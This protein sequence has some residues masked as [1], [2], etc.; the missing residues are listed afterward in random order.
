MAQRALPPGAVRR[1]TAFGLFDADGW[2]W[3]TIKATFW[4]LLILFLLGYVPDRFYYFTVSP[5]IDVG[6]NVIS[7]INLCPGENRLSPCPAPAGAVVP[8]EASP[9]QLALPQPRVGAGTVSSGENVYV[10]GGNTGSGATDS[11]L[12]SLLFEGNLTEWQEAT[13]LPDARSDAAV[14]SL[15]GTP[16]VIGGNDGAGNP[17][18][19]VFRGVIEEGR[20]TGWEEVE[21]NPLPEPLADLAAVPTINGIYVFG[22]RSEEGLSRAVY[23]AEF[24]SATSATLEQ[25]EEAT[26]LPLPQPRADA[27]AV[28]LGSLIYVLGG[29]GPDGPSD[30]VFFLALDLDGQPQVDPRTERPFGWGISAGQ[31]AGFALPEPRA[32]HASFVNAGA[33][34]VLGGVGADG[35]LAAS[36]FWAV[37]DS[38]EGTIPEWRRLGDTELPQAQADATVVAIGGHAFVIGGETAEGPSDGSLRARLAPAPPFFRLGLFGATV[39]ALG[40]GGEVGQELGYLSAAGVGTVNF[41]ILILVGWAYSHRRQTFRFFERISRGRFRAPPEDEYIV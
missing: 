33:M 27:S 35:Q 23:H 14:L 13:A 15:A 38:V 18:D 6:F 1:R 16:Y 25:W 32:R 41:V 29:E 7:P 19:T 40:I 8:W 11:V 5:T 26:E 20:L 34:Y 17:S 24:E 12:G 31:A 36:N 4:F 28:I 39:P 22:G 2:T 3:A 30:S 10:I 37:P 21:D 9:E